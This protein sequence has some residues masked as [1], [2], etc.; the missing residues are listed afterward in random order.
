M[1]STDPGRTPTARGI[2][3][4]VL[5]VSWQGTH[6]LHITAVCALLLLLLLLLL[7]PLHW[8]RR[9]RNGLG[10]FGWIPESI[11]NRGCQLVVSFWGGNRVGGGC[12]EDMEWGAKSWGDIDRQGRQWAPAG[13]E[14]T[15]KGHRVCWN[16]GGGNDS[17]KSG[18]S[19]SIHPKKWPWVI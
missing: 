4:I 7:L 10:V 8:P 3:R 6:H 13:P 2:T 9:S 17:W 18:C 14:V 15:R 12:R 16:L 1:F 19:C 5:V 11:L